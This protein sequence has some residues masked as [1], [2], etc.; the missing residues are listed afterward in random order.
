[1]PYNKTV[2][3]QRKKPIQETVRR[4]RFKIKDFESNTSKVSLLVLYK[5]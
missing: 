2:I 5:L 1:M 4:I 3:G